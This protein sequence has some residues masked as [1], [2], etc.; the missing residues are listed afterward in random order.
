VHGE[1]DLNL[2]HH[3]NCPKN[4]VNPE[5]LRPVTQKQNV[6]NRP[7]LAANNTSGVTG[8]YWHRNRWMAE[9]KH[10]GSKHYVGRFTDIAEAEAAVIAKRNELFTHNDIDRGR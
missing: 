10:N 8:V 4:C 9:V 5:H 7:G 3:R 1:T 6:E 2:D